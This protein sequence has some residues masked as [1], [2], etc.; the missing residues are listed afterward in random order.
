VKTL[1]ALDLTQQTARYNMTVIMAPA[2]E[3]PE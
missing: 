2:V 1:G 3:P